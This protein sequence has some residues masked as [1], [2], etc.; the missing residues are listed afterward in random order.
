M[1]T[2]AKWLWSIHPQNGPKWLWC[3]S[4]AA[5][6]KTHLS[7]ASVGQ[8][9]DHP[10]SWHRPKPEGSRGSLDF[11][12]SCN[13]LVVST[14]ATFGGSKEGNGVNPEQ[15]RMPV[16][17]WDSPSTFPYSKF[18]C[19]ARGVTVLP[20]CVEVCVREDMMLNDNSEHLFHQLCFV[21][22]RLY[23]PT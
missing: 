4:S 18:N 1:P 23:K 14:N 9:L 5:I 20:P 21:K 16:P 7:L 8:L 19:G 15:G 10:R 6:G 12:F 2:G 22:K 13:L 11:P 17:G 3:S